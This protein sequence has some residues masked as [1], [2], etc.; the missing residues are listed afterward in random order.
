MVRI[1]IEKVNL[2]KLL[3]IIYAD[4]R[5]RRSL[6]LAD[7][8]SD[9][10]RQTGEKGGDFYAPLWADAKDHVAGAIDLR[11]KSK[12]RVESNK[13]RSRLYP[14]LA[15]GFLKLW[16]EK[17]RWRNEKFN[18]VPTNVSARLSIEELGATVKVENVVAVK[19]Q[20]GSHRIVHPYF[21][22]RPAL[23][24]QGV[25]LGFWAIKEALPDFAA[26]DLRIV[27]I[28][29]NAYFRPSESPMGGSERAI[30]VQRYGS[31]L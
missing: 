16:N 18:F 7:I 24:S 6:L 29:C 4:P 5:Q 13:T 12:A 10:R 15:D 8:R 23:S 14:L 9:L 20:D 27:D 19:L 26:E 25:R 2:R 30:F 1:S 11:D 3:Q 22:E 28:L 17:A 21:S 31:V